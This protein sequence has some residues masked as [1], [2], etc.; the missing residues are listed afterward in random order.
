MPQYPFLLKRAHLQDS[1]FHL[2]AAKVRALLQCSSS[3]FFDTVLVT[4]YAW[5][6]MEK[7]FWPGKVVVRSTVVVSRHLFVH[8]KPQCPQPMNST[9]WLCI[10]DIWPSGRSRCGRAHA[11]HAPH[12]RA[13]PPQSIASVNNASV[14]AA[15]TTKVVVALMRHLPLCLQI[16]AP[17][18]F[19]LTSL[20]CIPTRGEARSALSTAA[21]SISR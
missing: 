11:D 16:A 8:I 6:C 19:R 3:D 9:D 12:D 1:E 14:A 13:A 4:G 15:I 21:F 7:C 17:K 10:L 20:P 5:D 2:T 18:K